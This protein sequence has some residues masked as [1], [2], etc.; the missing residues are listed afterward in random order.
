MLA[1]DGYLFA[2]P[3]TWRPSV[4][5]SR[6]FDRSYYPVLDRVNSRP[7]PAWCCGQ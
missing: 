3:E 6:I 7:M 5:N 4:G 1:A 2:T